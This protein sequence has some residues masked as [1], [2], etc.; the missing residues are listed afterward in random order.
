VRVLVLPE[1][2]VH[3]RDGQSRGRAGSVTD[4]SAVKTALNGIRTVIHL[5]AK[6]AIGAKRICTKE[7]PL[8]NREV[9]N[10]AAA[11]GIRAVLVSSIVVYETPFAETLR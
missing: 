4:L 11:Q 3:P 6:I 1:D 7:S 8:T 2:Q 9:F 5:V 10:V